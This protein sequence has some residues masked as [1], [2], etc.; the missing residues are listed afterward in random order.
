[1]FQMTINN[2]LVDLDYSQLGFRLNRIINSATEFGAKGSEFGTTITLPLTKR[3]QGVL[4]KLSLGGY[5]KFD[6][7][8]N[9]LYRLF[10][11]GQL[12]S[13]GVLKLIS[14]SKGGYK[15]DILGKDAEWFDGLSD[16]L[17]SELGYVNG[18]P[19][20]FAPY[21]GASTA[22]SLNLLTNADTD[23][24]FPTILYNN[25]AITDFRDIGV[26]EIFGGFDSNGVQVTEPAEFP[27]SFRAVPAYYSYQ[28]GLTF[29]DFPAAVF[30][31]NLIVR[32]FQ[33][34][35]YSP[36]GQ[37]FNEDWFN[38]IIL[39][40]TGEGF[41]WNW[42]TLAKLE[43]IL[44]ANDYGTNTFP[45]LITTIPTYNFLFLTDNY[46]SLQAPVMINDKINDRIDYV[47]NFNK[48][49]TPDNQYIVPEN[50]RYKIRVNSAIKRSIDAD[51]E[52]TTRLNM[53]EN[54]TPDTSA[55]DG[56][57]LILR[58]NQSNEFVIEP[59]TILKA[60]QYLV[61]LNN[62]FINEPSDCIAY[63][64]TYK[65]TIFPINDQRVS[66]SP[67]TNFEEQVSV[68]SNSYNASVI[69]NPSGASVFTLDVD[70]DIEVEVDMLRNERIE[71]IW[72]STLYLESLI[73]P[74]GTSNVSVDTNLNNSKVNIDYLCGYED[75]DIAGNLPSITVKDFIGNFINFFNLSFDVNSNNR[76]VTFYS[77]RDLEGYNST[78]VD[79]TDRVDKNSI[80]ILPV[81]TLP[82]RLTI[83]Y[84]N[85]ANDR[86]VGRRIVSCDNQVTNE[87]TDYANVI[88]RTD[89]VYSDGI[90]KLSNGFS[91]TRF[92]LGIF[93]LTDLTT[94]PLTGI[95]INKTGGNGETI[96]AAYDFSNWPAFRGQ[97]QVPVIQ[98]EE[99]YLVDRVGDLEYR[100]DYSPRLFYH[101]GRADQLGFQGAFRVN[102]YRNDA[103]GSDLWVNAWLYPTVSSFDDENDSTLPTLRLDT[104]GGI[105]NR[106]FKEV[107]D[108][109]TTSHFLKVEA[110]LT[111]S[112]Y[113]QLLPTTL[114]RISESLYEIYEV[115]E[116]D[117]TGINP[118]KLTLLKVV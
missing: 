89:N 94:A 59:D 53:L 48:W 37:I 49:R 104:G 108:T 74:S 56:M 18:Q 40:Y 71:I 22:N 72:I 102:A 51:L 82:K 87:G 54:F 91:A 76:T 107:V 96:T 8:V 11:R 27:N 17:L 110:Y 92:D 24:V 1:M 7:N 68:N 5:K 70:C 79:L 109:L 39:P 42:K 21:F 6:N 62:D 114:I 83:G 29:E 66:G 47:A 67:L 31:K 44:N 112:Q 93:D 23:I 16:R 105:Y 77:Q 9:Y 3:N 57:L 55:N 118:T 80:E 38:K 73:V 101:L 12:V 52:Q 26:D 32:C 46:F 65:S 50:G 115:A 20:W 35:G 85:D 45:N 117:I 75:L 100:Y 4:P 19:T 60:T 58:K 13:E 90:R 30:Y 116:F 97:F 69:T 2:R 106:Y 95:A 43:L 33:E 36:A 86:L 103:V 88:L 64:G 99:Q 61:G 84:D 81:T 78:V 14:I 28:Q 25:T 15:V 111:I 98:S 41:K 63:F 10:F 34:V 113:K